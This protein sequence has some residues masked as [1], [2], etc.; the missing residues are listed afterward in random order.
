[1]ACGE[2]S[3][4]ATSHRA[5]EDAL[6]TGYLWERYVSVAQSKGI[7]TFQ[8]L[9]GLG[10]HKYL[11]SLAGSMFSAADV[12]QIGRESSRTALKPRLEPLAEIWREENAPRTE[13]PQDSGVSTREYWNALA[14]AFA[15]QAVTA[16]EID[17]LRSEQ[18][19]LRLGMDAIR[20]VHARFVASQL[21]SAAEDDAVSSRES[22]A[23]R[24]LFGA[25]HAL[26]WAPGERATPA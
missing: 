15:D 17:W 21:V 10:S 6:A 18:Q 14:S 22:E 23:L 19:R 8:D 13:E 25:L 5:A 7:R 4:P 9:Q 11:A 16:E 24:E 12:A 1:V 2:L 20:G 3:L 26:G